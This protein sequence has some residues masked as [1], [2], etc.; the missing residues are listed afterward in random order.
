MGGLRLEGNTLGNVAEVTEDNQLKIITETNASTNAD[1]IGAIRIFHENDPG[2]IL[3]VP[4]LKSPE[5]DDDFRTRFA[6]DTVILDT[7]TFNYTSQNT[8]K[9]TTATSTMASAFQASGYRTN[10]T[11]ILT[12][13]S[14]ITFGTYAEFPVFG[15]QALYLEFN[16]SF[17]AQPTTNFVIDF[18][19]FRRGT[20]TQYAPSD[21]IYF[22]L[23][24][25]GL[26]GIG[27][28]SGNETS[29]GV[30]NFTYINN[31]KYK[32]VITFNER[33]VQFWI[34]DV[35]Y[36]ELSTPLGQG[37][38]CLSATLPISIRHAIP[39]S[40]VTAGAALTM[41]VNNYVLHAGGYNY[42]KTIGDVQNS[43]L[44]SYQGVSGGTMGQLIAGTV[45]TGTLVK[46]TAAIPSNTLLTTNLP[47]SLGGRAWEQ[48]TAGLALNTDGILTSYTNPPGSVVSQGKRLRI[49]G[50]KMSAVIQ[51]VIAGGPVTNEFYI[52]FGST[53]ASLQ[54]SEGTTFKTHRRIL[55]PEFT[56]IIT[57]T[58]PVN[59]PISQ[60]STYADFSSA[61]IYVNPQEIIGLVVN[62]HGTALTSGVIAYTYQFIYSWE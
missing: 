42:S 48:L 46:P 31:Q 13:N 20:A 32:F 33:N 59:T 7:E 40:T 34:D 55:I 52:I 51:T 23:N 27:N 25:A 12:A 37:Q 5:V 35:L 47:N 43:I 53:Q 57:A 29:T 62:R 41:V 56:Q 44:G 6:L 28:Y 15:A 17:D 16:A 11:G 8:G 50:L 49:T 3:G 14:G 45:T 30:F 39:A 60:I 1:K 10:S 2:D 4:N 58:Q 38:P 9:H 24:S 18:G 26:Q 54:A 19:L 36:G 21:G 22:R 61:P